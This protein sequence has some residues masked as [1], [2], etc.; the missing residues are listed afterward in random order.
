MNEQAI[1]VN[2][3]KMKLSVRGPLTREYVKVD[4][5]PTGDGAP[6]LGISFVINKQ[7]LQQMIDGFQH[8]LEV[9]E[10]YEA[11]GSTA[12]LFEDSE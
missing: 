4:I 5:H 11:T 10:F 3:N 7:E 9:W 2:I 12:T 6:M 1:I 8:I